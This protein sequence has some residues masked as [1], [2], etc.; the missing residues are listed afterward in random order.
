MWIIITRQ[1]MFTT[2]REVKKAIIYDINIAFTTPSFQGYQL[3]G[4]LPLKVLICLGV[5]RICT[6]VQLYNI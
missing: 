5:H 3:W 1:A 4:K 6:Y 2:V